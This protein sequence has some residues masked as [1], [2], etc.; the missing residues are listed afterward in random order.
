MDKVP[1]AVDG[2]RCL[3]WVAPSVAALTLS[4]RVVVSRAVVIAA[5]GGCGCWLQLLTLWREL[6]T[7]CVVGIV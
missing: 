7:G 5:L 2:D 1:S 6:S 4:L 3:P